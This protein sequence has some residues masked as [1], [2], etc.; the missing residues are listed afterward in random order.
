M[1]VERARQQA[2]LGLVGIAM[3]GLL[4]PTNTYAAK[5]DP[6]KE[7]TAA[8]READGVKLRG[9]AEADGALGMY[10][11]EAT[12]E[13]VV[14]VPA[15]GASRLAASNSS[16]LSIPVR[17]ETRDIDAATID[18]ISLAL[19]AV[20]LKVNGQAFGF[21]FDPESGKFVVQSEAPESAFADVE[22]A[23]PGRIVFREARFEKTSIDNDGQPHWGGA[24]VAV[25][26]GNACSSGFA[27]KFNAT[28]KRYMITAGHCFT[29]GQSTNMGIA[30]REAE[31]YPY[32]DFEF[33]KNHTVAGYV[34]DAANH[35]R[36]VSNASNPTVGST[37]CTTGVT[38]RVQCDWSLKKLN[39]T[40][41]WV[42]GFPD[43]SCQHNLASF[44]RPSGLPV[45]GGDSGGPLWFKYA[46]TAGIRGIVS[47]KSYDAIEGWNSYATQY[48]TIADYYRGVAIIP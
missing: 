2:R 32:W 3:L 8:T 41:C 11:D 14:V 13:Y 9:T 42:P 19:E 23:F 33:I 28:G 5:P 12:G 29:N 27:M 37:Y 20:A 46:S 31:A 6:T 48:A 4:A 15:N 40:I 17:V 36:P 43:F 38:S 39:Q 22:K 34:Y 24:K 44:R 21:G 35:G 18:Q 7:S 47:L 26:G 10:V 25:S 45:Q 30:V 16:S 1:N